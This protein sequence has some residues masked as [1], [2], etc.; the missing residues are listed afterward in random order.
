M[1][2]E[3]LSMHL[4][5]LISDEIDINRIGTAIEIGVGTGNFYSL[6]YKDLGFNTIAVD[7]IAYLPFLELA[8]RHCIIYDESCIYIENGEEVIYM[9]A[10][11]DLSSLHD[12]WWGAIENTG[13]IVKSQDL[14]TFL[15][16]HKIE[17]ISFLKVDTEGSEFEILQQFS[18]LNSTLLP[19]IIEFEYGG[20][21][22]RKDGIAGWS[23]DF[24][25][26]TL[27]TLYLLKTLG[28]K[29]AIIFDSIALEPVFF[30]FEGEN[31]F[32]SL[33]KP[34][35]EYGN[36]IAFNE[37]MKDVRTIKE[38]ILSFQ[39]ILLAE[40]IDNLKKENTKLHIELIKK[41]YSKRV[42]NKIKRVLKL[43]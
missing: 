37:K 17:K 29:E 28:Y 6:I 34:N 7:P 40:Y 33:F 27:K 11:S 15:G 36:V 20:G 22:L 21:G 18:D 35:F 39:N 2:P 43:K 13:K 24:Y 8:T 9:S 38:Q 25:E 19:K 3:Q 32:D 16:K 10:H 12:D 1:F 14:K 42:L 31:D 26:K 30:S 5:K 23:P 4:V 41:D